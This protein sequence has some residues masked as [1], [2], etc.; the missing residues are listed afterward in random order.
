MSKRISIEEAKRKREFEIE[1]Q[2]LNKQGVRPKV[3]R[4]EKKRRRKM[5]KNQNWLNYIMGR[6]GHHLQNPDK[7]EKKPKVYLPGGKI[8]RY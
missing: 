4:A 6:G 5:K 8:N 2:R 7:A 3:S 1:S